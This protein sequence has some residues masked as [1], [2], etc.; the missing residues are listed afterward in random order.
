VDF[1]FINATNGHAYPCGYR[2]NEDFGRVEDIEIHRLKPPTET[3][4]CRQCDWECFRDPSEL[5]GP[6]LELCSNPMGLARRLRA[7][8]SAGTAWVED[9]RY[10][11]ACGL[12]NGRRAP[13]YRRLSRFSVN[14]TGFTEPISSPIH[15]IRFNQKLSIS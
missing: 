4:A 9:L 14:G 1:F 3:D 2:G 7:M 15:N 12:F 11:R 5:F 8:P 10:Y 6:L 13:N